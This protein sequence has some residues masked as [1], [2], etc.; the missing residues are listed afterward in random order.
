[1]FS[2]LWISQVK[3]DDMSIIQFE[4]ELYLFDRYVSFIKI[5]TKNWRKFWNWLD[6]YTPPPIPE[7]FFYK[8]VPPSRRPNNYPPPSN[9]HR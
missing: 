7:S 4:I 9:D 5:V 2:V 3:K 1:M 8:K 6:T